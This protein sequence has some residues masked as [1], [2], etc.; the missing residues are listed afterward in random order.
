M[1]CWCFLD[2][3]VPLRHKKHDMNNFPQVLLELKRGWQLTF[4]GLNNGSQFLTGCV[5]I[6][7]KVICHVWLELDSISNLQKL[8]FVEQTCN[9]K[10]VLGY[11]CK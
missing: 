9:A 2:V 8:F 3:L 6:N 4:H 7:S 11:H 5:N 10:P 1:I